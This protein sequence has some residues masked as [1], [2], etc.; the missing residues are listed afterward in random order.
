MTYEDGSK[1]QE[2]TKLVNECLGS[3]LSRRNL[4]VAKVELAVEEVDNT[5]T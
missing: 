2:R 5:K 4:R 1:S 3:C